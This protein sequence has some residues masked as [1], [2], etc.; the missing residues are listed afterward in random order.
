MEKEYR[1]S[2]GIKFFYGI[3]AA[4]IFVFSLFLLT[5]PI[6]K[7]SF[8]LLLP[9]LLIVVS[10]L[11]VAN[12]IRRKILITESSILCV[13]L[14]STNQLN[15]TAIKGYRLGTKVIKIEPF[16]EN[17]PVLTIGNYINFE[18]NSE[19]SEWLL[20]NFKDLDALDLETEHQ[21]LLNDSSLGFTEKDREEKIKKAKEIATA[22]NVIGV[23]LGIIMMFFDTRISLI[24]ILI[25]PVIGIIILYNFELIRFLSNSKRSVYSHIFIGFF[26][27]C[28]VLMLKS[29]E[30]NLLSLQNTWL[31]SISIC[32]LV[33]MLLYLKGI[34]RSVESVIGQI[35]LIIV[36][37]LLYGFGSI[38]AINCEFD[39]S[40]QYIYNATVIDHSVSHGKRTTYYIKLSTWG[41]QDKEENVKVSK[42]M[43]KNTFIGDRV[44]VK[45]KKGFLKIP[46]FI[47]S[48]KE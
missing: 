38:R 32:C 9:I 25:I 18:D 7:N 22:Y 45:F 23:V 31:L 34:N 41:P 20:N 6:H 2:F 39:Q 5:K 46:W 24:I 37:S 27:S 29:S 17:D 8:V 12:F 35:F 42:P 11:I 26:T 14:F 30:F 19:I 43:Y 4:I 1:L 13:D 48:K 16:S 47:V 36:V 21:R 28:V 33:F 3:L 44:E 10:F 40:Q 15:L